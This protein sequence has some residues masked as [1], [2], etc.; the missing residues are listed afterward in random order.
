MGLVKL[1]KLFGDL[2]GEDISLLKFNEFKKGKGIMMEI[3]NSGD[4]VGGVS[5][6]S[7]NI[8]IKDL[9]PS[10]AEQLASKIL[11]TLDK[12]TNKIIDNKYQVI[13]INAPLSQPTF[14]GVS[15]TQEY[16]FS[17][18]IRVLINRL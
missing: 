5:D 9:H 4:E 15:D 2:I 3:I 14:E 13:L 18:E 6:T 11:E 12:T 1:A 10:D 17:V 8:L 7:V 16:I